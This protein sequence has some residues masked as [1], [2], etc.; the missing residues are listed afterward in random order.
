M[1]EAEERNAVDS[2]SAWTDELLSPSELFSVRTRDHKIPTRGQK[3]FLYDGSEE[4]VERLQWSLGEHWKLLSEER[5]ER[6]GSL[7]KAEWKPED[8]TVELKTPAGKFWQTMGYADEGKQFLQPEEALFLMECGSVE[9]FYRDLPLSIQEGYELLL[10]DKTISLLEYLV[11]SH[12]KRLG[13]IVNRFDS[14]A[15]PS[16]YERRLNLVHKRE[17]QSKQQRKRKR[18]ASAR[19]DDISEGQPDSQD[20]QNRREKAGDDVFMEGTSSDSQKAVGMNYFSSSAISSEDVCHELPSN[21]EQKRP[22]WWEKK[23]EEAPSPGRPVYFKQSAGKRDLNK[24]LFPNLGRDCLHTNL[25]IPN[26]CLLPSNVTAKACNISSWREKLNM[27]QMRLTRREREELEKKNKYK[28][29]VNEDKEVRACKNWQEYKQLLERRSQSSSEQR[30][31]HLWNDAV[32]PLVT[33]GQVSSTGDLLQQ[34]SIMQASH[35]VDDA[36]G[37]VADTCD[38]RITF[39]VYQ[40]DTAFDFKKSDPGKPYSRI[41]VCSFEDPVPSLHTLKRLAQQSGDVPVTFAVVDNGDISF[42]S[43]KDFWLPTDVWQ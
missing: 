37:L 30:P 34:I 2:G 6:Q 17:K 38:K 29:G 13:Y 25:E 43:F 31:A 14:S 19:S 20:V 28:R 40:A 3:E 8:V 33:P 11:F 24:V 12:L 39:D 9:V 16:V 42:Y 26:A 27:R 22:D 4:Q 15:V 23:S 10:G 7:V 41:S 36:V 32:C 1:A 35:L 5:A 21:S 18:S